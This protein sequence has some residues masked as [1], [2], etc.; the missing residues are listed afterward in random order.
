MQQPDIVRYHRAIALLVPSGA[1]QRQ[2]GKR[3]LTDPSADFLQMQVHRFEVG[4]RQH[5]PGADAPRRADGAEQ[6]GP[7]IALI[8]WCCRSAA[9]LR[10]DARQAALLTN[11]SFV[12]PPQLDRFALCGRGDDG[13][14]QLGEVF[15]CA[16][17]AAASAWGWR[18]RTEI[19][20]NINVFRSRLTL[21]SCIGKIW[22]RRSRQRQRTTP[23]SAISDPWRTQAASCAFSSTDSLGDAPPPCG[24]SDRP[25]MPCS[26]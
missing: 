15:L 17:C 3:P 1:Y 19:W 12:L 11:T 4:V 7:L 10:P 14:D 5:E 13:G 20:L 16:S 26:L 18:G 22:S 2:H 24:R 21:R 6:V 23:S 8:A 9:P 25:A